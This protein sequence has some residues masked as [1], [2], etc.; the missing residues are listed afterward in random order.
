MKMPRF[1]VKTVLQMICLISAAWSAQAVAEESSA[2]APAAA[3]ATDSQPAA[4]ATPPSAAATEA[5]A[6]FGR[7][8]ADYKVAIRDIEQLRIKYQVAPPAEREKINAELTGHVAHAQSLVNAMVEAALQ[9]YR[10]EPGGDPRVTELLTAVARYETIGRDAKNPPG[11]IDGGDRFEKAL[12][13]INELAAGGVQDRDLFAWGFICAFATN[14]YDLAAKFLE[15]AQTAPPK[16]EKEDE[17]D[18][19]LQS[20]MR[21]ANG[22]A[23]LVDQYRALW[24]KEQ[25]IRAAE[26]E[27]DD[28]PRVK[29]TT[30]KGEITLELFENE[31]PQSVA[32][33]LT[34]VKQGFYNG[35]PFHRVLPGFMAQGGAK[36]DDG[37]GGPGYCI[38]SECSQPNIRSHFRG[39]LS[40]AHKPNLPDSGSSQFFLTFVPTPH[41]DGEHTVFGRVIEGLEVLGDLQRRNPELGNQ[42]AADRI[43]KAEVLRDRGHEYKFDK[44]PE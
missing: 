2:E 21:L 29:L 11:H 24:E 34:L 7:S 43:I 32:S 35:S 27:A 28:L 36:S 38:R 37:R 25:A 31:A 44:L 23:P 16:E 13:L 3:A 33:F 6:A 19:A 30:S 26:A 9:A 20:M 22:F 12:P 1:S 40:M 5:K 18:P 41:L 42:P 8:L 4:P 10:A 39:S 17:S 14:D 15:Q